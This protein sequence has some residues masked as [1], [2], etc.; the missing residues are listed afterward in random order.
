MCCVRLCF[1]KPHFIAKFNVMKAVKTII[2]RQLFLKL[3]GV[4]ILQ[5]VKRNRRDCEF[6]C[7]H[8]GAV[9]V[10]S[11]GML[12]CV[13]ELL[14]SYHVVTLR[15]ITVRAKTSVKKCLLNFG[16]CI[17]NFCL[18]LYCFYLPGDYGCE[19]QS[20]TLRDNVKWGCFRT[21]C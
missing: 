10:C 6:L 21:G 4:V 3:N 20:F 7:F 12:Y 9:E 14:V 19:T 8:S 18:T 16:I 1:N 13:T 15:H 11:S 5:C 17:R 2:F